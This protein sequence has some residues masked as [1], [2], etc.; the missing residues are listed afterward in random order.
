MLTRNDREVASSYPEL[1]VLA[2]RSAV[3][4]VL[5]GEIVAFDARGRPSFGELQARMHV[6]DP[7]RPC[8]PEVPVTFLAFDVCFLEGR[9]LL[10]RPYVERRALLEGLDVNG[11]HWL[12]PP[13]FDGDGAAARAASL[14]QGLEGVLAKRRDSLYEAGERSRSWIKVKH[15][16][17]QEV[18]ICGWQPGAGG[19]KAASARCCSG[20]RR[21]GRLVYAGHVGTGFTD[22]M[23]DELAGAAATAGAQ[24][25]AARHGAC[26]GAAG[27]PAG[28]ARGGRRGGVR[29]V[30]AR[31]PAAPPRLARA[32]PGQ[33]GRGGR[34][35]GAV[36]ARGPGSTVE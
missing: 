1:V 23:L 28:S 34:P 13:A 5:D 9:S 10:R 8:A 33:D 17:M 18:V 4:A 12:T 24:D 31:R 3:D 2:T 7:P 25:L 30:D 21:G 27:T 22:R 14:A 29:R 16:R 32:A 26:H 11:T 6:G 35:R 36:I 15:L 19:A 20:C